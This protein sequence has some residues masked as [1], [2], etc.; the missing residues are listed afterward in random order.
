MRPCRRPWSAHATMEL[1]TPLGDRGGRGGRGGRH[2][3][4]RAPT[5][6]ART[7]RIGQAPTGATTDY[8]GNCTTEH[9]FREREGVCLAEVGRR[10]L[11][12][13]RS[14]LWATPEATCWRWWWAH[15]CMPEW[16]AR[17]ESCSPSYA[18]RHRRVQD[19]ARDACARSHVLLLLVGMAWF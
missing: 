4:T 6:A 19:A 7:R 17:S 12:P 18:G 2:T 8:G 10:A 3:P 9:L 15:L 11:C 1:H 13:R 14:R 16:L 5:A